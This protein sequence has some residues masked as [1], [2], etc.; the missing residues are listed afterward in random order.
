M[1]LSGCIQNATTETDVVF[2]T[3]PASTSIIK[4]APR[5]DDAITINSTGGITVRK[6][7]NLTITPQIYS[8]I[9]LGYNLK[10]NSNLNLTSATSGTFYQL[11]PSFTLPVGAYLTTMSMFFNV[12]ANTQLYNISGGVSTSATSLSAGFSSLYFNSARIATNSPGTAG[13]VLTE[14]LGVTD[15]NQVYYY[16]FRASIISGTVS[17]STD[18][19]SW[20]TGMNGS[21]LHYIKIG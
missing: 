4:I 19:S 17:H 10:I 8:P 2:R 16:I 12:T 14:T 11:I 7:I 18:V 3:T 6:H 1:S 5:S 9:Q 21:F 15:P 20:G 13:K